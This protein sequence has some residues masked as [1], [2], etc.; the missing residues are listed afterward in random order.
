MSHSGFQAQTDQKS[1]FT[2][3]SVGMTSIVDAN[4]GDY[5]IPKITFNL[6]V[7]F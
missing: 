5:R 6:S 7:V 4:I 1:E 2:N 3:V